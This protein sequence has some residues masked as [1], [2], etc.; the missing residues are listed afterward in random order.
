[1]KDIFNLQKQAAPAI[2]NTPSKHHTVYG[3]IGINNPN[4]LPPKMRSRF[5]GNGGAVPTVAPLNMPQSAPP[6]PPG[7]NMVPG[8]AQMPPGQPAPVPVAAPQAPAPAGQEWQDP[9]AVKT[10]NTELQKAVAAMQAPSEMLWSQFMKSFEFDLES[11]GEEYQSLKS[12]YPDIDADPE[13]AWKGHT[14][15]GIADFFTAPTRGGMPPWMSFLIVHADEYL[16]EFVEETDQKGT[17]S[18]MLNDMMMGEN[19]MSFRRMEEIIDARDPQLWE[20]VVQA[21]K[22][23]KGKSERSVGQSI[24]NEVGSEGT[25]LSGNIADPKQVADVT[26]RMR[27]QQMDN[28]APALNNVVETYMAKPQNTVAL[29]QLAQSFNLND[30]RIV[31]DAVA[32]SFMD[33]TGDADYARWI[34]FFIDYYNHLPMGMSETVANGELEDEELRKLL[35]ENQEVKSACFQQL[36][37]LAQQSNPDLISWVN[38]A[39]ETSIKIKA[40]S[41]RVSAKK[42][43]KGLP[44]LIGN[45]S[46]FASKGMYADYLRSKATAQNKKTPAAQREV[47][48][49]GK[50]AITTF[51]KGNAIQEQFNKLISGQ[52]AE[53]S[54]GNTIKLRN[55]NGRLFIQKSKNGADSVEEVNFE[56]LASVISPK[57][58]VPQAFDLMA[59]YE[60]STMAR[61]NR[62]TKGGDAGAKEGKQLAVQQLDALS[63]QLHDKA[64]PDRLNGW[65]KAVGQKFRVARESYGVSPEDIAANAKTFKGTITPDYITKLENGEPVQYSDK[66][67]DSIMDAIS[68]KTQRP[69]DITNFFIKSKEYDKLSQTDVTQMGEQSI[70][71]FKY[72]GPYLIH[73]MEQAKK[74]GFDSFNPT[75]LY[76]Y[77]GMMRIH[78][79]F[80]PHHPA[81]EYPEVQKM[82]YY[83]TQHMGKP[84]VNHKTTVDPAEKMKTVPLQQEPRPNMRNLRQMFPRRKQPLSKT[85][86]LFSKFVESMYLFDNPRSTLK[87]ASS[88]ANTIRE[89]MYSKFLQDLEQTRR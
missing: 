29:Q 79:Q 51:V 23:S 16:P 26:D 64:N 75:A 38:S 77:L 74:R 6:V 36:Q 33:F 87:I 53:D 39:A 7:S 25:D 45:I 31:R 60:P 34:E 81:D 27:E 84:L 24:N 57:S 48:N 8:N 20:A 89:A 4:K 86:D 66:I 71:A 55:E 41:D 3:P 28:D 83:L 13:Q 40:D 62:F 47:A 17:R 82:I 65:R 30:P 52:P 1:M 35:T 59:K 73:N 9:N 61:V 5:Q 56:N 14:S 19:S 85:L 72:W 44:S 32:K 42:D 11:I 15:G 49:R 54:N 37:Q 63:D 58:W 69:T 18:V 78:P 43:F 22:S 50:Y 12:Q 10:P 67:L 76:L 68:T 46:S 70:Y 88:D 21:M 2:L 80:S